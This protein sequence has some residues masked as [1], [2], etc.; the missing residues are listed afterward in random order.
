MDIRVIERSPGLFIQFDVTGSRQLEKRVDSFWTKEPDTLAWID[1]M[2]KG[3][4]LIDVGANCGMYSI[5][6]GSRGINVMAFE[7]DAGNFYALNRNILLN[8]LRNVVAY[9]IAVSAQKEG[10]CLLYLSKWE[11]GSS[12]HTIERGR[13][14]KNRPISPV[15][16]Q[17]T[18]AFNL[19]TLMHTL[20]IVPD[21]IK[22]DVDSIDGD[23]LLNSPYSLG[24]AHSVLCELDSEDEIHKRAIEYMLDNGFQVDPEQI[25]RARRR[26]GPNHGVGNIIFR[27]N[28]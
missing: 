20:E 24:V 6:A 21:Y 13:T 16:S 8:E 10:P 27:R 18:W 5:Y 19:D 28:Q 9:P 11:L 17:G 15:Y 4:V 2:K 1:G 12:I 3:S 22:I 25:M 14:Y 23:I 26:G 7:P